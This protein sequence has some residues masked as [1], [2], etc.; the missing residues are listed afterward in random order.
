MS[1][2]VEI[3]KVRVYF[4]PVCEEMCDTKSEAMEHCEYDIES[5]DAYVCP[6][7]ENKHEL[8]HD[9]LV[10]CPENAVIQGLE[11]GMMY[12]IQ[13]EQLERAGQERMFA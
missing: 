13:H 8:K 4:C 6:T 1:D 5:A 12:Q 3:E 11:A 2:I 9:A 7:C 10:C